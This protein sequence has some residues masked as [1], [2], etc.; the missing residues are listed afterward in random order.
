MKK[1]KFRR[2]SLITAGVLF[3]GVIIWL[4]LVNRVFPVIADDFNYRA[5]ILSYDNFF[6]EG[7]NDF[8]GEILSKTR[9]TYRVEKK[10]KNIL[11]IY[12]IFDVRKPSGDSIF[13]VERRYGIDQLTGKHIPGY[14]DKNR[15]GYLF[16]PKN[17]GNSFTYWH[18]NYDAPAH[19]KLAGKEE[20][21]GL[22]VYRYECNYKADQT[23]N[24][25][26]LP[27]VPKERGVE[28]DINLMLWVEPTTGYLIK[29]ED[30]TTAWYYDIKSKKRIH[31]WN[32]FSN[33]FEETSI[34]NQIQIAKLAKDNYSWWHRYFPLSIL[35]FIFI[36]LSVG[37]NVERKSEWRYY[38]APSL[39]LLT[40]FVTSIF[41]Y[42]FFQKR[43]TMRLESIFNEDCESIRISVQRE[44]E[45]SV[46]VLNSVKA[47]YMSLKK[48]TREQFR[49][50]VKQ[51]LKNNESIQAVG[52]IP[53]VEL[54]KRNAF[55]I[56]AQE[57]GFP[58]FKFTELQNGQ[59]MPAGTRE[60][61]FPLYYIEPF[62]NNKKA[63]RFDLASNPERKAALEKAAS[64]GEVT[65]TESIVLVQDL[66]K[67]ND[68]SILVFI[69][70][71]EDELGISAA[72]LIHS[73]LS[74]AII[75]NE[76]MNKAITLVSMD[77]NV[78]VTVIDP[79][80]KIRE[81]LF[82]N[83]QGI[84]TYQF[85]KNSSLQ[86]AD[87]IWRLQFR[88]TPKKLRNFEPTWVTIGLP[89]GVA[90]L[91]II[92]SIFVFRMLTDDRKKLRTNLQLVNEINERKII[93]AKLNQNTNEL[94]ISNA[95]LE[96]FA[97]VASHDLQEPLRMVS[98]FL[99]LL[100]HEL[101]GQL[102]ETA[103]KYIYFAVDGA[104]RMKILVN[105]LL[106]YSRIGSAK[107]E[108][109]ATDMNEVMK[110]VNHILDEDIKKNQ[111][112]I[113]FEPMPVISANM[114]LIDQLLIN[115]VG[116]ALK[117]KGDKAPEI[118]VGSTEKPDHWI[119]YVKDNGI[120][121]DPKFFDK[122]F[123]IFQR[124]HNQNEYSGTGI[125]LAI[126][127]KIVEIHKGKI[128]V[129]SEPDKGSA[130]YFSIPKI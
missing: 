22:P 25:S 83:A 4:L 11:T 107:E 34:S 41:L 43:N 60:K 72:H 8:S 65:A 27:G 32:R 111:A 70:V 93:T 19:M 130:F 91:G 103:K 18:I 33:Q 76:L 120:G 17:A 85:E 21:E 38:F 40:G 119:F 13:K 45:R 113:T 39:I 118:S 58:G 116:N 78:A 55:E 66:E 126:C 5:N 84:N 52:F 114:I 26:F 67:K 51:S 112:V 14:G 101:E 99:G 29:Y 46:E 129:E 16:A 100:E 117:Y 57:E 115:L 105:D 109:A 53:I 59:I 92:L 50:A 123:T 127:K 81:I 24:L 56:K 1:F 61:Y 121:I 87:R 48:M 86:V 71:Y 80:T 73:Y 42:S 75:I 9:Y 69:P 36:V 94:K 10:Q 98:S 77:D 124:L 90:L 7:K 82:T 96:R 28:L 63:F 125:G 97:Y 47:N 20:I 62:E 15:N 68:K 2:W 102:N 88:C 6:D 128:W 79:K 104:G 37:Y 89:A 3:T 49:V 23:A 31:P 64:T 106:E 74:I 95:E 122:I 54:A 108:F 35:F 12:N 30:R 44:M 110:Y